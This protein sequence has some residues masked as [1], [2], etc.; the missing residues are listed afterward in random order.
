M[1]EGFGPAAATNVMQSTEL[2]RRREE[3][4]P[5][6]LVIEAQRGLS[7]TFASEASFRAW[8]ELTL[9][10]VY[11]YLLARS[12]S[13]V[14]LAEDL[15]QVTYLEAVRGWRSF[16]GNSS[17]ATWLVAIARHKL[18]DHYRRL[19][20]R[21]GPLQP[22]RGIEPATDAAEWRA[23]EWPGGTCSRLRVGSQSVVV[24]NM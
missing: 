1:A 6:M 9:P 5:A 24:A 4:L 18:V 7:D 15:T 22:I 19:E 13:D 10:R 23:I 16:A 20:R 8:Y 11:G 12:G 17:P 3:Q 2:V 14:A 21:G